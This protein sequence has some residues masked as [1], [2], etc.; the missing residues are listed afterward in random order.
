MNLDLIDYLKIS[1]TGASF[2]IVVL[3]VSSFCQKVFGVPLGFGPADI[4][5]ILK[6]GIASGGTLAGLIAIE[7]KLE[8]IEKV[9]AMV[10]DNKL[11]LI[12]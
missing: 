6:V 1:I 4:M 5:N 8:I 3:C 10:G 12:K 2:G 9:K 7:D 11:I